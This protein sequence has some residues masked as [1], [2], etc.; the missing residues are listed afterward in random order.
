MLSVRFS[1]ASVLSTLSRAMLRCLRAFLSRKASH[2]NTLPPVLHL[3]TV[4]LLFL[5]VLSATLLIKDVSTISSAAM[6]DDF[7]QADFTVDLTHPLVICLSKANG[8]E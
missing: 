2:R 7:L 5:L 8:P 1:I 3:L 6:A 4:R